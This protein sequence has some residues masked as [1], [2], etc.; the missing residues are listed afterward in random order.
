MKVLRARLCVLMLLTSHRGHN[1]SRTGNP[2]LGLARRTLD[3]SVFYPNSVFMKSRHRHTHAH[4]HIH[5]LFPSFIG[6]EV[7]NVTRKL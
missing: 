6:V 3:N 5:R 2:E 7:N 4:T 1:G